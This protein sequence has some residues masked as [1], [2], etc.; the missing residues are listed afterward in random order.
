VNV[1]DGPNVSGSATGT[2]SLSNLSA[3]LN[4]MI[5]RCVVAGICSPDEVTDE[6]ILTLK[7]VPVL[8]ASPLLP[9]SIC[10]GEPIQLF[11]IAEGDGIT[12][13]W[14]S[15][16]SDGSFSPISTS[17]TFSGTETS[18]LAINTFGD[19]NG[20]V[21]RC[22]ITG[23]GDAVLTDAVL[24]TIFKNSPVY[25]P[26]SFTPDGDNINPLFKIYTEGNPDFEASVYNRWGELVYFWN[27]VEDGWDGSFQGSL[28]QEGVYI[29]RINYRNQCKS[30]IVQGS[31]TV[32][33]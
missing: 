6:M 21:V 25:I 8:L 24:I 16:Q 15:E 2:L 27:K 13:Q 10:S 31:F 11:A 33:R 19:V 3:D 32:Y 7:G 30:Q 14:E 17:E 18:N 20:T 5:F 26:N 22:R 4:D 28:A 9:S 29:Y 23:C 1:N 12:Y